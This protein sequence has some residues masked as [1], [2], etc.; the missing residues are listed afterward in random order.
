MFKA[1]INVH[2]PLSYILIF[3]T[4]SW[5]NFCDCKNIYIYSVKYEIKDLLVIKRVTGHMKDA[6]SKTS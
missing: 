5:H 1:V 6:K 4:L 3:R 2:V